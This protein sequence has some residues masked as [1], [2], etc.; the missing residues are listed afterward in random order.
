VI[1]GRLPPE[2]HMRVRDWVKL[3]CRPPEVFPA[4]L[5]Y[6]VF[7]P[8]HAYYSVLE[9]LLEDIDVVIVRLALAV[10]SL[11]KR[12]RNTT[13]P[14]PLSIARLMCPS[15]PCLA[16]LSAFCPRP[17]TRPFPALSAPPPP[18]YLPSQEDR[19]SPFKPTLVF[20]CN[21]QPASPL[22]DAPPLACC[23]LRV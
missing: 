13:P 12:R 22:A 18:F 1:T 3:R 14:S 5:T 6:T 19:C 17:S 16:L 21:N 4:E 2:F 20:C 8:D 9:A 23:S 7:G 15:S 11:P 10:A